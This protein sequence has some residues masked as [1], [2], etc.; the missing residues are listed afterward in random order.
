MIKEHR[1][2]N[3][4]TLTD[5]W[6]AAS[7][8]NDCGLHKDGCDIV[9]GSGPAKPKVMVIGEAPGYNE[10]IDGIPFT[11][12]AGKLLDQILYRG[13]GLVR[14]D[15][16]FANILKCRPPENRDPTPTETDYCTPWLDKQIELLNPELI[17]TVGKHASQHVLGVHN[18]TMGKMRDK[19]Y[20]VN[21]RWVLPT[22]HPA[23]LLRQPDRNAD[24]WS[25]IQLALDKL[26][27]PTPQVV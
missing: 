26:G 8:C 11:G 23:Y 20:H 16:Y 5:L 9:F 21:G 22:W 1:S 6:V 24:V 27:W 7:S 19:I 3:Q 15:V 17:I 2:K 4:S 13:M 14:L 10:E 25:D 12:K 18:A